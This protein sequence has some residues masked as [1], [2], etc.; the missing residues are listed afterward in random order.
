V[1]D[2]G[3]PPNSL[4]GHCTPGR[5]PGIVALGGLMSPRVSLETIKE[6]KIA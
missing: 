5:G 4:H 3:K 1:L 6:R 2:E